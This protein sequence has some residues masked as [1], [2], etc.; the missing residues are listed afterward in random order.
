MNKHE[1]L[2]QEAHTQMNSILRKSLNRKQTK[3]PLFKPP[4]KFHTVHIESFRPIIFFDFI[5]NKSMFS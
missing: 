4:F 3:S 2:S 1:T 5:Q